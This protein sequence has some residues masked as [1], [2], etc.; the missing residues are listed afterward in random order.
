[1]MAAILR[2]NFLETIHSALKAVAALYER[3]SVLKA[4]LYERYT[5]EDL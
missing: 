5:F 3:R 1:M 4:A 2:E